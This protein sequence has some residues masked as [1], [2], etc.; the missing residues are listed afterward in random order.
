MPL[1]FN[2]VGTIAD[3][4]ETTPDNPAHPSPVVLLETDD[5]IERVV[6]PAAAWD[7]PREL[8]QPGRRLRIAG[9]CEFPAKPGTLPVA[10]HVEF[11]DVH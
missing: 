8:L 3:V 6:A 9:E 5:K 2:L 1:Y 4:D 10:F 7:G 11:V